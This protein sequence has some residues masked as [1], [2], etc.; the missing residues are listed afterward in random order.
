MHYSERVR[1]EELIKVMP[2]GVTMWGK[3]FRAFISAAVVPSV[4]LDAATG[5]TFRRE[6]FTAA[7][8]TLG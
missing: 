5:A 3:I 6:L 4:R 1:V 7:G 2:P 8:T